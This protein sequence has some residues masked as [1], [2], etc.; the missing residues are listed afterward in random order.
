MIEPHDHEPLD[1]EPL[2]E[3]PLDE[4]PLDD[5]APMTHAETDAA[6]D[7]ALAALE[8]SLRLMASQIA[9]DHRH[10]GKAACARSRRCRGFACEPHL[11]DDESGAESAGCGVR[12]IHSPV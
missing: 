10:C 5:D 3:E 12:A 8:R 11:D 6:R 7:G 1:E 4:E 9:G 2:D